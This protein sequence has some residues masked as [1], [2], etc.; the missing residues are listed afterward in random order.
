[1]RRLILNPK[2]C[3]YV[4]LDGKLGQEIFNKY[5]YSIHY[6]NLAKLNILLA[7]DGF[8]LAVK[9]GKLYRVKQIYK[10]VV[11]LD[12]YGN[13]KKSDGSGLNDIG[14]GIAASNGHIHILKYL[15]SMRLHKDLDNKYF[16]IVFRNAARFGY[17]DIV[18][19]LLEYG[20]T[21]DD[22]TEGNTGK[23]ICT[24]SPPTK[25]FYF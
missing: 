11:N 23:Y 16:R 1:M 3:K 9:N 25:L 15:I 14:L 13:I 8:M 7:V 20:I 17:A 4:F 5:K 22:D 2:T 21:P 19:F 6:K 12:V 18:E 24:A 10:Q